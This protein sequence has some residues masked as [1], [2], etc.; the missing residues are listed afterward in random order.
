MELLGGILTDPQE[1]EREIYAPCDR[2]PAVRGFRVMYFHFMAQS[3]AALVRI[4][5]THVSMRGRIAEIFRTAF[6]DGTYAARLTDRPPCS[7]EANY[8]RNLKSIAEK[9]IQ[10]WLDGKEFEF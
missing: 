2:Y 8:V 9:A 4:G 6:A 7:V 3:V 5:N 10:G 1:A